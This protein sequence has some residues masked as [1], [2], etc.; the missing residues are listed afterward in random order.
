MSR[1]ARQALLAVALS[2]AITPAY[3]VEGRYYSVGPGRAQALHAR[4]VPAW[5][6]E[7]EVKSLG[8]NRYHIDLTTIRPSGC[9]GD[10]MATGTL[11][12]TGIIAATSRPECMLS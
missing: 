4:S 2:G 5:S 1:V 3:A 8:E 7:A 10:V 6:T 11:V 12:G 9:T